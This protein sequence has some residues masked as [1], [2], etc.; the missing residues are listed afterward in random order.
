MRNA[1]IVLAMSVS[2]ICVSVADGQTPFE[3]VVE[4]NMSCADGSANGRLLVNGAEI[5]RTLEP[6]IPGN[7]IPKGSYAG[8]VRTDGALGWRIELEN[9]TGW[10][11]AQ[12]HLGN[13]PSNT[14]GCV[15]V[16][17]AVVSAKD[18]NTGQDTCAVT[19]SAQAIAAIQKN[20]QVASIG[21]AASSA[22][23]VSIIVR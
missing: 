19:G 11:N 15:L 18:P 5:A 21:S 13:F 1:V 23:Q 17:I 20:M 12:I 7:Q 8:K 4:R 22:L 14:R 2:A 6:G 9:V 3:I 10:T 16:G